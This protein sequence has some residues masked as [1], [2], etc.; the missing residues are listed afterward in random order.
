[1]AGV[2]NLLHCRG[3]AA[4]RACARK[5]EIPGSCESEIPDAV[6]RPEDVSHPTRR[7]ATV[8]QECS[9][10]RQRLE[11]LNL[12]PHLRS[13]TWRGRSPQYIRGPL[14]TIG[15][16]GRLRRKAV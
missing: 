1:M 2:E 4:T 13:A 8:A 15:E 5:P 12:C 9:L 3:Q 7:L 16:A 11:S 6:E 14:A 10:R